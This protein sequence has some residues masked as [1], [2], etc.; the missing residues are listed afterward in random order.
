MPKVTLLESGRI[1]PR[2]AGPQGAAPTITPHCL[3]D[4]PFALAPDGQLGSSRHRRCHACWAMEQEGGSCLGPPCC[5]DL[6]QMSVSPHGSQR[7]T[8]LLAGPTMMSWAGMD[9][10]AGCCIATMEF[11]LC[12]FKASSIES[13]PIPL[14]CSICLAADRCLGFLDH[15]P[16]R[17]S[18]PLH[19]HQQKVI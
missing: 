2:A 1:L 7:E 18:L 19:K 12:F 6:L 10:P 14:L 11:C 5:S 17:K 15:S 4:A 9:H 8:V 16:R 3:H 13:V